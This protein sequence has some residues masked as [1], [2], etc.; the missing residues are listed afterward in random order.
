MF[1]LVRVGADN[2][3]HV[4]NRSEVYLVI[5][6]IFLILPSLKGYN[7]RMCVIQGCGTEMRITVKFAVSHEQQTMIERLGTNITSF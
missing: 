3:T 5:E 6:C 1:W 4:V 7:F 2:T